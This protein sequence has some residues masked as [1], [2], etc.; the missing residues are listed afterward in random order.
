M[1]WIRNDTST[2]KSVDIEFMV[3]ALTLGVA[4]ALQIPVLGLFLTRETASSSFLVG[5][6]YSI[7]AA[8]GVIVSQLIAKKSDAG[9]NRRRLVLLCCLF[10]IA[11]ALLFAFD[12]RYL[13]LVTLGIVLSSLATTAMPQLFA[14]ARQYADDAGYEVV[15]FTTRM[16]AQIS[17]SWVVGP[18]FA[19]LVITHFG[20]T[21][22]YL[23]VALLFVLSAT[24]VVSL[25]PQVK[26]EPQPPTDDE[27]T[28]RNSNKVSAYCLFGA[29]TVLWA[30]DTMYLIDM[31]IYLSEMSNIAEGFAGWLLGG[32]AVI[33]IL[34]MF[35]CSSFVKRFGK[36][37]MM[38]L[39]ATSAALFY[40][41]M[42]L[43]DSS[44]AFISIQVLGATFNGIVGGL[45]IIY[46][47]E[48]MPGKPGTA[49]TLYSNS[50][51]IG[52]ILAGLLQG[53]VSGNFNHQAVYWFALAMSLLAL[54]LLVRIKDV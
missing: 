34:V 25:L 16:R 13:T 53:T 12:R 46:L 4:G 10:G 8:A 54:S 48:L 43:A 28:T 39:A 41:G 23:T 49:S 29:L 19:F 3:V 15:K 44:L 40:L 1:K 6:F 24:F 2:T 33:E 51:S 47:Q 35:S 27:L 17:I 42:A 18:P 31:P 38:L 32:A 52:A 5:L 20:F 7:N 30:S 45:G 14:L 50:I 37:R 21:P 9:S 11:N 36:R 26:A 22:L